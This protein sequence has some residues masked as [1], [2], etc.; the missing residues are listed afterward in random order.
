MNLI[1]QNIDQIIKI[2]ADHQVEQL[3]IFG[4]VKTDKF[5]D[6]SDVDMLLLFSTSV[7]P[8]EYFNNFMDFKERI[9]SILKREVDIVEYQSVKNPIFRKI[10]DREKVMIYERKSA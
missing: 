1:N 3:Y 7:N 2:C 5:N 6:Q 9:E 8:I 4:S 10:L